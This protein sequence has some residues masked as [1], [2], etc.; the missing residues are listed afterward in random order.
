M[1]EVAY[2]TTVHTKNTL[3]SIYC[4]LYSRQYE[5]FSLN[6]SCF[7]PSLACR[8]C[9]GGAARPVLLWSVWT[10]AP[11]ASR[12]A[13]PAVPWALLSHLWPSAGWKPGSWGAPQRHPSTP[14]GPGQEG[15]GTQ[16]PE[17][18]CDRGWAP[19]EAHQNGKSYEWCQHIPVWIM[20]RAEFGVDT[21]ACV[22]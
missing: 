6:T 5:Y 11:E 3:Y 7:S 18:P 16:R 12:H 15:L 22:S 13:P 14:T 10:R 17:C 9:S 20:Y 1:F 4:V 8:E 2:C 21:M 19:T